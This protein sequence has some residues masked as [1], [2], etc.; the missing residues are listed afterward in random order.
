MKRQA[1]TDLAMTAATLVLGA[2]LVFSG[3]SLLRLR[4]STTHGWA[5]ALDLAE[6]LGVAGAGVGI[7]LL[8]WWLIAMA[9]ACLSAVAHAR[10]AEKVAVLAER[11]SPA[12]MRRLTTA[13]LSLN[14][15]ATPL[16][17]AANAPVVDPLW[18]T[19]TGAGTSTAA[20]GPS[21]FP[22][23]SAVPVE[24]RWIPHTPETAP[25]LLVPPST[26]PA[27][28]LPNTP[29]AQ[30]RSPHS[31]NALDVVVKS[32]DS[33]WTI[34]SAALGPFST[35]VEV[36]QAWPRWY[37]ANRDTIG[38]DPNYILPGQVLHAPNGY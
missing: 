19:N 5:Q 25:D 12:F 10:G 30:A 35:D 27:M 3:G 22:P 31:D 37:S 23:E 33:L 20:P 34:A 11:C 2:S 28:E 6:L 21:I 9:C 24:P 36:A 38:E 16:L 15:L 1:L 4:G 26:R 18:H 29:A 14:L 17:A 8:C 7:A 13:V 32:G